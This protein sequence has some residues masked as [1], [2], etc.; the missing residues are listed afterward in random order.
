MRRL[1]LLAASLACAQSPEILWRFGPATLQ[2]T[3]T[4]K[5]AVQPGC[6]YA[7]SVEMR[8]F[9][10]ATGNQITGRELAVIGAADLSW[11]AVLSLVQASKDTAFEEYS[12][13]P[14]GR[15][16]IIL[17][18]LT[19]QGLQYEILAERQDEKKAR[20]AAD[21]LLSALTAVPASHLNWQPFAALIIL[22]ALGFWV[23][24]QRR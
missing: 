8:R 5:Q 12:R 20:Q 6:V 15:E 13:E 3:P 11:F 24:R 4:L 7:R 2:L 17:T 10:K 23:Y 9:L 21:A 22:A 18:R 16:V 19:A 1:M 14:D